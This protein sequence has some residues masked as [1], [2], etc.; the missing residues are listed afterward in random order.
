[1][2]ATVTRSAGQ[3]A[4]AGPSLKVDPRNHVVYPLHT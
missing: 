4:S 2:T 1:M 3:D